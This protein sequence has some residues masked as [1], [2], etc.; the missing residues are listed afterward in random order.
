MGQRAAETADAYAAHGAEFRG[1]ATDRA[2]GPVA[3]G[4]NYCYMSAYWRLADTTRL[5][6]AWTT[7][8]LCKTP[9]EIF[10]NDTIVL[11]SFDLS[12]W[13]LPDIDACASAN[14]Y[15]ILGHTTALF[16]RNDGRMDVWLLDRP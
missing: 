14:G 1:L 15:R 7:P 5:S 16:K 4:G 13:E 8:I 12:Q 11:T 9:D 2:V 6:P 10:Q 3:Y